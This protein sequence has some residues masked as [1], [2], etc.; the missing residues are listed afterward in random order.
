MTVTKRDPP[1]GAK[2]LYR[3][4][5]DWLGDRSRR[6]RYRAPQQAAGDI[7]DLIQELPVRQRDTLT[8][9][10]FVSMTNERRHPCFVK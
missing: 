3:V 9:N 4:I 10:L 1:G 7:V 8:V 6:R 5:A 2:Q